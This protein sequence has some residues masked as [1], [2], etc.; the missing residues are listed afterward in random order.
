MG[1]AHT[2]AQIGY[3]DTCAFAKSIRDW[4][5]FR[6][7]RSCDR[8]QEATIQGGPASLAAMHNQVKLGAWG[9]GGME[10]VGMGDFGAAAAVRHIAKSAVGLLK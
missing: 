1:T 3:K 7:G 9:W 8:W 10:E 2:H 5:I 6:P 4:P